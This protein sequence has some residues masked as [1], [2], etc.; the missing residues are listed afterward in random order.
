MYATYLNKII[1]EF[2]LFCVTYVLNIFNKIWA[3][4]YK[5]TDGVMIFK[6]INNS[7]DWFQIIL[8]KYL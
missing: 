3:F 4:R 1:N 6:L 2:L 8:S 7:N 5:K